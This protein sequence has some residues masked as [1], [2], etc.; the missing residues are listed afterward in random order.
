MPEGDEDGWHIGVF[1]VTGS[2][3]VPE[4][5]E[6]LREDRAYSDPVRSITHPDARGPSAMHCVTV[7]R[8]TCPSGILVYDSARGELGTA[9]SGNVR[10]IGS[11]RLQLVEG[12]TKEHV[13]HASEI[14]LAVHIDGQVS[15]HEAFSFHCKVEC[16]LLAPRLLTDQEGLSST[17]LMPVRKLHKIVLS[18][19]VC[20]HIERNS[21]SSIPIPTPRGRNRKIFRGICTKAEH[22]VVVQGP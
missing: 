16:A 20:G 18:I 4:G 22:G 2:I 5:R 19:L 6:I 10:S 8:E 9:G 17:Y 14:I 13:R 12:Q 11:F 21:V 7:S 3:D 1:E 15:S